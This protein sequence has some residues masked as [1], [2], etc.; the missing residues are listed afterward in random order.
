MNRVPDGLQQLKGVSVRAEHRRGRAAAGDDNAVKAFPEYAET[1]FC[2]SF[3]ADFL[4]ICV[5]FY[6]DAELVRF[7]SKRV[8][9]GG[10]SFAARINSPVLASER[11]P[12]RG[13]KF[14]FLPCGKTA[15]YPLRGFRGG[16]YVKLC[17][18]VLI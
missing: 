5:C 3:G 6:P 10:G 12:E 13:E 11:N 14:A 7:K 18:N 2:R 15:Q 1:W 8:R 17:G 4:N 16:G 9:N